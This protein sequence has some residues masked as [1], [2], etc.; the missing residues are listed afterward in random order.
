MI[1]IK[2]NIYKLCF[3]LNNANHQILN[4]LLFHKLLLLYIKFFEYLY[5]INIIKYKVY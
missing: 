3:V 4:H 1:N 2:I 5:K